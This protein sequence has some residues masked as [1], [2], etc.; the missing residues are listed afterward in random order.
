MALHVISVGGSLI[1][2][3]KIDTDFLASFKSFIRRRIDK[4][5]K[6]ILIAGGG[7]T[8]RRYQQGASSVS[9]INNEDKDWLGIHSSRLNGHLLR[10]I[11]KKNANPKLITNYKDDLEKFEEDFKES[12][13]VGAG[14]K[15]G[16]ST[17]Y[18]AVLM[19]QKFNADSVINLSNIEYVYSQDPKVNP[20]AKKYEKMNWQEF[21]E[22]IGDEWDPGMNA[23]FD[24]IAAKLANKINLKVI[25]MNGKDL[26]N[27]NNYMKNCD[28]L[29]TTIKN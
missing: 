11:F 28:F 20:N 2:P 29:G 18:D 27:L 25:I 6:F 22:L 9:E 16:W 17:D 15:P 7:K 3:D 12:I 14:W 19:A 8:C 23:P 4:G 10:T 5:D 26:D 21:I 1:V 24:P 13:L